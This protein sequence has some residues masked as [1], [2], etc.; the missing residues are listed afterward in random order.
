MMRRTCAEV[1]AGRSRFR[2]AAKDRICAGVT[3]PWARPRGFNASNPPARQARI[4]RSMVSLETVTVPPNG[5]GWTIAAR[6]LTIG[7]R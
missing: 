7:P 5:P 3:A 1:R 2:V 4:H 6:S